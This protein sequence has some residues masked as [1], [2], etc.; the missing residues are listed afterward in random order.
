MSTNPIATFAAAEQ[1]Q[2]D[3]ANAALD[4]IVTG[5]AALDAMIQAFQNSPGTLSPA[6]QAM[7]DGIVTASTALAQRAAAV[8]TAPPPPPVTPVV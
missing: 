5:I 1:A 6:D 2:I 8:S 3:A 4:G 7:L